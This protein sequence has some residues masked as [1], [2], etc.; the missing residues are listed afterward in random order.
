MAESTNGRHCA[1]IT[2]RASAP[3]GEQYVPQV[4]MR[5]LSAIVLE[6]LASLNAMNKEKE[7]H[8]NYR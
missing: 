6:M 8:R 4:P 7:P 1:T 5:E 2:V 3:I